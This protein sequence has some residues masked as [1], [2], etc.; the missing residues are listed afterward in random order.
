MIATIIFHC[1]DG[2][3]HPTQDIYSDNLLYII[4]KCFTRSN[5][6]FLQAAVPSIRIECW[7]SSV[8][9]HLCF[10]SCQPKGYISE[11]DII[12][13]TQSSFASSR[14]LSRQKSHTDPI[15]SGE[16]VI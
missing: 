13:D 15:S 1:E 8:E 9:L 10:Y 14:L 16:L 2:K 11:G 12:I 7:K 6:I 3:L 4:L 5:Q